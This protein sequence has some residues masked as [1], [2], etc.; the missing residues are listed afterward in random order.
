MPRI[1]NKIVGRQKEF[2]SLQKAIALNRNVLIEGPVGVG[3]TFLV[4]EVLMA[5]KRD[6]ERVDG[7]TRYT[8]SKLTGWFDPPLV[9]KKGYVSDCFID[10]PLV[11]AMRKGRILFI[12]ELNR[13]PIHDPADRRAF[14]R[15]NLDEVQLRIASATHSF[16]KSNDTILSSIRAN[17]AKR[18]LKSRWGK[19]RRKCPVSY[20]SGLWIL[21]GLLEVIRQSS[22][23]PVFV[24][25]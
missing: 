22:E 13:M 25:L 19:L 4:R 9:L 16:F 15:S 7:D 3:K 6:F 11:S 23:E 17:H 5:L 14:V 10:G 8:E 24:P 2:E 1:K 21:S 18:R 12:N 20:W